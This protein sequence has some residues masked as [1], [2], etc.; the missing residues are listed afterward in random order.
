MEGARYRLPESL[1]G[2]L[3]SQMATAIDEANLSPED[4]LIAKLY[5]LDHFA[6]VD[7]AAEVNYDRTTVC[8]RIKGIT[9]R[10]ETAAS[11]LHIT[12]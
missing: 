12:Q 3:T 2:L 8:R 11:R 5:F 10:V 9:P 7:I 1:N 6:Q 4:K